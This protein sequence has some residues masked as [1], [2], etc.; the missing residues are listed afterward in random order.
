[1]PLLPCSLS[2][3]VQTFHF[4]H[5]SPHRS[6]PG[7][8]RRTALSSSSSRPQLHTFCWWIDRETLRG[9]HSQSLASQVIEVD[10]GGLMVMGAWLRE[11]WEPQKIQNGHVFQ[12]GHRDSPT[13]GT[14]AV[15]N[16]T[17]FGVS[18]DSEG[19]RAA[20]LPTSA[21]TT[22]IRF[23]RDRGI[24]IGYLSAF[25]LCNWSHV[26]RRGAEGPIWTYRSRSQRLLKYLELERLSLLKLM[27]NLCSEETYVKTTCTHC[28]SYTVLYC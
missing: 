12:Q 4:V 2:S 1:M 17:W 25:C 24:A 9:K 8:R 13:S 21:P 23:H 27:L 3:K 11:R 15:V 16:H 10:C 6:L 18:R 26:S 28:L 5:A 22:T 19:S 20:E 14:C 7:R